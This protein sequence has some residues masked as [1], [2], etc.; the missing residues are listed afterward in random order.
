MDIN[1]IFNNLF[2]HNILPYLDIHSL[3][4]VTTLNKRFNK[5][6]NDGILWTNLIELY[7]S[8]HYDEDTIEFVKSAYQPTTSKDLFKLIRDLH[9]KISG[10]KYNVK[11][12]INM[13]HFRGPMDYHEYTAVAPLLEYMRNIEKISIDGADI[14]TFPTNI[15]YWNN[16]TELDIS[17]NLFKEFPLEICN[18]TNLVSLWLRFNNFTK[19]PKEIEQ[20]NGMSLLL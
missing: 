6:C 1:N 10:T 12:I 9:T 4:N 18:F 15:K 13:K 16:V 3:T 5:M 17:H 2:I 7:Y 11:E 8:K 19:L 20:L 14:R